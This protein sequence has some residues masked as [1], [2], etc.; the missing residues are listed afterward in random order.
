[1]LLVYALFAHAYLRQARE[2]GSLMCEIER[3]R[4]R[5]PE[6]L[7]ALRRLRGRAAI[8]GSRWAPALVYV[9]PFLLAAL[10]LATATAE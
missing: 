5:L 10:V 2:L 8:F 7:A 1:M 9:Y 6:E 3:T 4:L